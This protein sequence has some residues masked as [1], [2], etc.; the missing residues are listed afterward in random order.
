[1]VRTAAPGGGA[2]G[3]QQQRPATEEEAQPIALFSV[4]PV[5]SIVCGVL[6]CPLVLSYS[7]IWNAWVRAINRPPTPSASAWDRV[8][9]SPLTDFKAEVGISNRSWK[10]FGLLAATDTLELLTAL[11][12]GLAVSLTLDAFRA[13]PG[14]Q[15]GNTENPSLASSLWGNLAGTVIAFPLSILT[16][17]LHT[18]NWR[19]WGSLVPFT[20]LGRLHWRALPAKYFELLALNVLKVR[21]GDAVTSVTGISCEPL[22]WLA[23]DV[24]DHPE[25]PD[26][27]D[28]SEERST[29][30]VIVDRARLWAIGTLSAWL[31][32]LVL[33]GMQ[34]PA[35]IVCHR[36]L[37]EPG[38]FGSVVEC[39]RHI[40]ASEGLSG[41]YRDLPLFSLLILN[42][43]M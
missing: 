6:Y 30:R 36:M 7:N 38:R 31:S 41:F 20:S 1:M 39:V 28:E 19:G 34:V 24:K 3:S 23:S 2:G 15:P 13:Q 35:A 18:D 21:L 14:Q 33:V 16:W 25:H 42:E 8:V 27:Y 29:A 5:Y 22:G 12:A 26:F 17:Q 32:G 43:L 9:G 40:W 4:P 11:Y 10:R 37:G